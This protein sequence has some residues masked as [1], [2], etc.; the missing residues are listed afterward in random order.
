MSAKHR[1]LDFP[2][3][4]IILDLPAAAP[5]RLELEACPRCRARMAVLAEFLTDTSHPAGAHPEEAGRRLRLAF[6]TELR[7]AA[8]APRAEA[9]RHS[10]AW[11]IR[12]RRL[13]WGLAASLALA[14]LILGGRQRWF[15]PEPA[16]LLRG[17]R[18]QGEE[19]ILLLPMAARPDGSLLLGWRAVRGAEVYKVQFLSADLETVAE[20][21]VLTDTLLLLTPGALAAVPGS[22][23][24]W[25]VTALGNSAT[26]ARSGIVAVSTP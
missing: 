3:L 14:V 24:A 2:E 4:E 16:D 10:A 20:F 21:T 25:Q 6:E 8:G 19:A 13:A 1:C 17:E 22:P 12:H 23:L 26:L 7:Q 15:A 9:A 5:A 11:P 18:H